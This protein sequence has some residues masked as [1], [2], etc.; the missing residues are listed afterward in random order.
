M[1]AVHNLKQSEFRERATAAILRML[2]D[3]PEAQRSIFIWNHYCGYQPKQIA[4]MLRCSPRKV[5]ATLDLISSIL[6][7]RTRKL[8]R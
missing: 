2:A 6:Y 7:Q 4:Q 3:L 5:E 1:I 8:M